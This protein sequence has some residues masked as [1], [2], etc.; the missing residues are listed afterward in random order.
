MYLDLQDI[1]P[2]QRW[3]IVMYVPNKFISCSFGVSNEKISEI[4]AELWC[5]S[6][7][8]MN[9]TAV[10]LKTYISTNLSEVFPNSDSLGLIFS[11]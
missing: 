6:H 3:S 1:N 5:F 7:R 4:W 2:Y 11:I 8:S 10:Q 9:L